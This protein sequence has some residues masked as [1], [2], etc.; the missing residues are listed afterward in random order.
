MQLILIRHG[1]AGVPAEFAQGGMNDD[2]RPLTIEG[3]KRMRHNVQGLANILPGVDVLATSPLI[4][5]VETAQVV[6]KKFKVKPLQLASLSPGGKRD[7]IISFIAQKPMADTVVLVG[8]EPGLSALAVWLI[9]GSDKILLGL[10]KGGACCVQLKEKVTA[11][12][13]RLCWMVT[14]RQ[15]RAMR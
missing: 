5:A 7:K 9:G 4:R 6:G 14:P 2:L 1:R 3:L 11:G 8:H 10:K 15:L 13:G 12:S